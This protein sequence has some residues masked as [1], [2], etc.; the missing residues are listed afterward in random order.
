MRECLAGS[1]QGAGCIARDWVQWQSP[2]VSSV[3]LRF[4]FGRCALQGKVEEETVF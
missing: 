4:L 1:V 2:S 3:E